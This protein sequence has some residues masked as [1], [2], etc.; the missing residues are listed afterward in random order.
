MA[1][2]RKR[3]TAWL[4]NVERE[5]IRDKATEWGTSENWVVRMAIRE[6]FGMDTA[7][8][9]GSSPSTLR[10]TPATRND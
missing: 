7:G 5:A 2:D 4:S 6:A 3:F 8:F 9:D 10:V 1:N